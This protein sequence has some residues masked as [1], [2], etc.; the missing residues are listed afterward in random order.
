MKSTE[1]RKRS[2]SLPTRVL[3]V[4]DSPGD[5]SLVI[6]ALSEPIGL[7]AVKWVSTLEAAIEALFGAHYEC[8]LVELGLP[9]ADGLDVVDS[10]RGTAGE[11]A[12]VVLTRRSDEKLGLQAI[13]HGADDCILKSELSARAL[14]R[15]INYAIERTRS[16]LT[17]TRMSARTDAVMTSL[18]DGLLVLDR[19]GVVV[20]ANPAATRILGGTREE[21]MGLSIPTLPCDLFHPDGSPLDFGEVT[22]RQTLESDEPLRGVTRGVRRADGGV[23]WIE[24]N[25]HPLRTTDDQADGVVISIH[26][27]TERL[28]AGEAARFQAALLA[29]VGQ[30]VIAIDP[31]GLILYWNKAAEDMYGWSETEALNRQLAV[32]VPSASPEK[33]R[34]LIKASMEGTGWTGDLLSQRRDGTIFPV[35]ATQTPLFDEHGE[36]KALIGVSTDISERKKAED[37]AKERS[38][39]VESTPDGVLTIGLDG[40]ILTWNRGAEELYGYG[41]EE[42]IGKNM[43][44]LDTDE[45]ADERLSAMTMIAVGET[46]RDFEIVRRRR[47]GSL[48]HVSLTGSPIYGDDGTVVGVASIGR[49]IT[50]RKRLEQELSHQAVHDSLTGLPNRALLSD[51]L[52][53]AL[54]GASRR[55]S[56]VSVLFLDLDQFKTI[57][58]ANGHLVGDELLVEVAARLGTAI[59]PSDTLARFGGDEFVVV[60]EDADVDEAQRIA[61]RL[62]AALRDPIRVGGTLQYVSASIGIAVSPPLEADPNALLRYA[63]TAMYDAKARGRARSRV[64]DASLATE[65]K[66]RL[67]LTNDLGNALRENALEV[68]YQPV[69]ELSTGRVVG[70]EALSRWHHSVRGWIPPTVFVPLAEESGLIA[71]FDRWVLNRA[72]QDGAELRAKG[73]LPPDALLSVNISAR[74]VS[75]LGLVEAVRDAATRFAFPLEALELEVT[76]TAI[77][78]EVP[79]IRVVLEGIREIGVGISLDDFGT[80]YSSLTFVRQLPVTTIKIDRSFTRHITD[81]REDLA[82]CASVIDLARAVGLRTIAEGVEDLEQL[83]VLSGLG[84]DAGQGY[85]WS[86]ALPLRDLVARLR[87]EPQDFAYARKGLRWRSSDPRG[88]GPSMQRPRRKSTK[89]A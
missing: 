79:T 2:K 46:I 17:V 66:D 14:H 20:S 83:S 68:H 32:L 51:R 1:E 85:L 19:D 42:I 36:L 65:S 76:E 70:M 67:E 45:V 16:K 8:L 37:A 29:S 64:F 41:P 47:D 75:D 9:D 55:N 4:E 11:S 12:L 33:L 62:A 80:G 7:F 34:D 74:N 84:C 22:T 61:D 30:A 26:D 48:V 89:F 38:A 71:D 60:C 27:I 5:A 86:Q 58:D 40:T 81:R 18:G 49:D 59:R 10:L 52:T 82:I 35:L 87:C 25:I 28:A 3:L 6:S 24:V 57:N 44:L 77:M 23:S 73:L 54:A 72:C 50:D 78:A 15:S 88:T 53:Q 69:I 43:S 56:P 13:Q 39:I 31:Q 63:D 21:L